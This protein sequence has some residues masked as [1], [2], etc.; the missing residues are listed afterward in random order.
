MGSQARHALPARGQHTALHTHSSV[1]SLAVGRTLAAF[2]SR[3]SLEPLCMEKMRTAAAQATGRRNWS[4]PCSRT[5]CPCA[6]CP[7]AVTCFLRCRPRSL[8][9]CPAVFSRVL[10]SGAGGFSSWIIYRTDQNLIL[11]L[12]SSDLF[13]FTATVARS[14]SPGRSHGW[15]GILTPSGSSTAVSTRPFSTRA[16]KSSKPTT[17]TPRQRRC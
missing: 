12:C 17:Q 9:D 3:T 8:L 2:G 1:Q 11:I 7:Q 16:S 4:M 13:R 5:R 6:T 14:S 10:P 15:R